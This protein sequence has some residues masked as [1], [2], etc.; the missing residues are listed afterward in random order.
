MWCGPSLSGAAYPHDPYRP[1]EEPNNAAA[2]QVK[3]GGEALPD[4]VEKASL[5]GAWGGGHRLEVRPRRLLHE[6][7]TDADVGSALAERSGAWPRG[8]DRRR[9]EEILQRGVAL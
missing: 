4:T 9:R 1:I 5:G 2:D 6:A 7:V 8:V 3:Q